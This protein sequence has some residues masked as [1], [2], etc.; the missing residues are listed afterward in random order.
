M[1]HVLFNPQTREVLRRRTGRSL[2]LLLAGATVL[3]G[4]AVGGFHYEEPFLP[5]LFGNC[6]SDLPRG[7]C[8]YSRWLDVLAGL[9]AAAAFG[10]FC[11]AVYRLR[12]L[13]P[14]VFCR[15]CEGAGWI[16]DLLARDGRCPLCGHGRFN[17]RARAIEVEVEPMTDQQIAVR[18]WQLD[19]V[20]GEQLLALKA[21]KG[22]SLN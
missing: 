11:L 17:Y 13:T 20:A 4:A 6:P 3:A 22:A 10:V 18:S 12:R 1:G 2:R 8:V 5:Y 21:E 9:A 14:T 7:A 19:D 15:K 16:E